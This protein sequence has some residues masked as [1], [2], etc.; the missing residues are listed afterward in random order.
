M[1]RFLVLKD[2]IMNL[3]ASLVQIIDDAFEP[4]VA[5]MICGTNGK[6]CDESIL[7]RFY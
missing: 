5:T 6:F 7:N 1:L 3:N 2:L 4:R